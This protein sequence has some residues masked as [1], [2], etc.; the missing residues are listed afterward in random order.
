MKIKK[1]K[2][3]NHPILGS[4][5]LDF[6]N[7]TNDGIYDTIILAGENGTGKTAILE[8]L[9][10]FLNL[11][12]FEPF[13]FI[14]YQIKTKFYTAAKPN[15]PSKAALGFHVRRDS[16]GHDT[17]INSNKNNDFTRINDDHL[18]IRHY[19]CVYSKARS[20]F[21]T[22]IITSTT[23]QQLDN[24]KYGDDANDDFTSIKQLLVDITSQDNATLAQYA[25]MNGTVSWEVFE[26]TS[27]MCRFKSAFK[28]FF[29]NMEFKGVDETSPDEKLVLFSKNNKTIT[30]DELSTGEKQVVFRGAYLLKDSQNINGGTVLVDEPE[31]SMHPKW[32]REILNYYRKLFTKDKIQTAQLFVATHSEYVITSGLQDQKNVLVIILNEQGGV[33][34]SRNIDVPL[35]LPTITSAETNY[36]A[37]GIMSNDYH[38]E[39][40]GFLQILTGKYKVKSCDNY[41]TLQPE[42]KPDNHSKQSSF[43]DRNSSTTTYETLPTYIRNAID[44]PDSG[45]TFTS[46][47]LQVSIELLIELCKAAKSAHGQTQAGVTSP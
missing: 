21:K 13:D 28:E 3:Q 24:N 41:I 46:Q 32:Q 15:D 29:G 40:Y 44:H 43:T 4:L 33:I 47:E 39:L 2:W 6:T 14:K 25:K 10:T 17:P 36:L 12:S 34:S 37:F 7:K 5:E 30:I 26:P 1:I 45:N 19:G 35:I 20:G 8:T 9:S 38:I 23:T 27:K 16:F 42:Y 18:D 22:S 11:G 31:L